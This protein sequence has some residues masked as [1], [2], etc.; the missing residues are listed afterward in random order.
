MGQY[1]VSDMR[2]KT[3]VHNDHGDAGRRRRRRRERGR[4][5]R[6]GGGR[7]IVGKNIKRTF[8]DVE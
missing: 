6:G 7:K 4:W 8:R 1:R 3:V 2:H 5:G